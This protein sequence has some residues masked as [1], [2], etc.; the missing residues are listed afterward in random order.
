M[1]TTT[2]FLAAFL[3]LSVSTVAQDE[4][5]PGVQAPGFWLIS[6]TNPTAGAV[7]LECMANMLATY[8]IVFPDVAPTLGQTMVV[9]KIDE[10]TH[11]VYTTWHSI[12]PA[13]T[14][15]VQSL[16][17]ADVDLPVIPQNSTY[18][19]ILNVPGVPVGSVVTI[20]PTTE[21]PDGIVIGSARVVEGGKVHV[22]V[23]NVSAAAI[24]CDAMRWDV[25]V[26]SN[27]LRK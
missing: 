10:E 27:T 9:T 17:G 8:T 11:R 26:S 4:Q 1:K 3:M 23:V 19:M 13:P 22:R 14:H 5:R 20:N 25:A 15:I 7:G 12:A 21:L 18:T 6:P 16:S 2:F 24:D